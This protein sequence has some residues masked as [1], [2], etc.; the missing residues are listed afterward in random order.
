MMKPALYGTL[1]AFGLL[2]LYFVITSSISGL[3]FAIFQFN[4]FWF[5][6]VFL[7]LGFGVQVGLYSRL[8]QKAKVSAGAIGISG[9]ASGAAMVSCCTHYLV[10]VLPFLGIAGI[11]TFV[12]QYQIQLFWIGILFNLAGIGYVLRRFWQMRRI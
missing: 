12:A 6:F 9:T 7:A 1:S 2:L 11:I 3:N 5:F 10:N 8:R 4:K